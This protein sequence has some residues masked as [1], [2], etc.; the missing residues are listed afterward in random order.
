MPERTF[1][2]LGALVR[3]HAVRLVGDARD[4]DS[5]LERVGDRRIVLIG[6]ATHGTHE[7]YAE[8]ADITRRLIEE[9]GFG[10]V[11]VEADWP[12]AYRV[13]RFVRDESGDADAVSALA[14][15]VRFPAWMWRNVDVAD[16]ID[17]LR[18]H[19]DALDVGGHKVGFY[20]L[21]LYSLYSS[22]D[23]VVRYLARVDP[24][25]ARRAQERYACFEAAKAEDE[26][27]LSYGLATERGLRASCENEV[28]EQLVELR[29]RSSEL[30]AAPVEDDEYFYAEQNARVAKNAERYYR[31]MFRGRHNSWNLRDEHMMEMLEALR[32]HI[33]SKTGSG[34][35]VV[36]AHN[37]HLGNARATEM[38][39][40]GQLNLGQLVRER[41]GD[42]AVAVGFT[43]YTGTVTAA[44]D[45]GGPVEEKTVRPGLPESYEDLFH[46]TGLPQFLLHLTGDLAPP[47]EALPELHAPLGQ[48]LTRA[49]ERQRLERAIGVI[50]AP[51]TER[52]SHYF[53]ARLVGQFDVVIHIDETRALV[54]LEARAPS[55]APE[56]PETYPSAL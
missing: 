5:L 11:V 22:I 51:E 36:W 55:P 1:A 8:R 4:Y 37:S 52:A 39:D 21:D 15:F 54:P 48:P 40:F 13:N 20:G 2:E 45:W 44:S 43:T 3:H 30:S 6:E 50:Y 29:Q 49:L 17:W 56:L 7:F 26:S 9:K 27:G 23:E 42:D 16:F 32:T 10:A 19:N 31:V 28:V 38:A 35:I 25:A 47:S 41:C 34:K 46:A 53:H 33:E 18:A 24:A 14:G 12:D